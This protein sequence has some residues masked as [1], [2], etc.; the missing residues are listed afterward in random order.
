MDEG[1]PHLVREE[2][3]DLLFQIVFLSELASEEG[4]FTIDD[5]I[6]GIADKMVKRHPHVFGDAEAKTALDAIAQSVGA[7]EAR[8]EKG[9]PGKR[10]RPGRRPPELPASCGPSAFRTRRRA[11]DSTGITRSRSWR[12]SRRS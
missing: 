1:K 2:L 3:G 11:S 10:V 12:R 8:R 6:A 7:E 4:R 5:V 9:G